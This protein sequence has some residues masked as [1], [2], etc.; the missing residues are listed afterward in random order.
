MLSEYIISPLWA[1]V[2]LVL[3]GTI[4]GGCAVALICVIRNGLKEKRD[5]KSQKE[6]EEKL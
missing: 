3:C 1:V 4:F 6:P 2:I 5:N